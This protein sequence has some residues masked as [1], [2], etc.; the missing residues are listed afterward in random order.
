MKNIDYWYIPKLFSYEELVN[1]H[2][3]FEQN[4][5]DEII[6]I[7][8]E[9]VTK[10]AKVYMSHW[11]KFKHVLNY[12]DQIVL[13]INQD[14]FG[15]NIWPQY[16]RNIVRLNEYDSEF[17][18]EYDWHTDGSQD[19]EAYDIKFTL[20]MNASLES[21]EGG[22]FYLFS[23]GATYIDKL[24]NPGDVLIFKSYIPHRVTPVT[25]GKRHSMTLFYNGPKFQ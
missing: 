20:L 3:M 23:A 13:Q 24:D 10:K 2:N 18:G 5:D 17:K 15:F 22:K 9:N 16:D 14:N 19:G 21:Y 11:Y 12:L 8:A 4:T 7:P 6:D 1:I 25:K